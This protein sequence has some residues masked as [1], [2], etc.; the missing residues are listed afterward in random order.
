MTNLI[1]LLRNNRTL[2]LAEVRNVADV[3]QPNE[4]GVTPLMLA[5]NVCDDVNVL[6]MLID[7]GANVNARDDIGRTALMT[8]IIGNRVDNVRCLIK[9]GANVNARA[10]YEGQMPLIIAC[11]M[12]NIDIEIVRALLDAWAMVNATDAPG[13]NAIKVAIGKGRAD[14][15]ELLIEYGARIN[16]DVLNLL[17]FYPDVAQTDIGK[18]MMA[19]NLS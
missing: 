17:S 13:A 2:T 14:V 1:D 18:K 3:N 6:Q 11:D 12:Q 7:N 9:N 8:A 10:L 16:E 19:T 5:A 4:K 15:I